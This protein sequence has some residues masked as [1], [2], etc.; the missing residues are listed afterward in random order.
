MKRITPDHSG[1][2][3]FQELLEYQP[4]G[5]EQNFFTISIRIQEDPPGASTSRAEKQIY[6]VPVIIVSYEVPNGGVSEPL[7][8]FGIANEKSRQQ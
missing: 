1:D 5:G 3:L 4:V 7:A 6:R 8:G 2:A